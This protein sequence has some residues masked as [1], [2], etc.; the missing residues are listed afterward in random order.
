MKELNFLLKRISQTEISVLLGIHKT[1]I[2]NWLAFD[3]VPKK[4]FEELKRLKNEY[5]KKTRLSTKK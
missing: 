4:H 5:S 3:R 1:N 2:T